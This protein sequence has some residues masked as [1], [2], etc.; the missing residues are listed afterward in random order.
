M[1]K[2]TGMEQIRK[3]QKKYCSLAIT[4][5]I[6]AGIIFF[7]F[8][9]KPIGKGLIFGTIF[10]II[11]FILMGETLPMKIGISRNKAAVFSFL[12][13][14]LRYALLAI[15]LVSSIKLERFNI[16]AT[17]C[18]LFMVQLVILADEMLHQFYFSTRKKKY[19]KK[20]LWKN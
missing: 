8:D 20:L 10:S 18:G 11:N 4:F 14:L 17:V 6:F 12:S 5:A 3:T 9:L 16:G 1:T 15:P 2:T 19:S 13:I 7:L